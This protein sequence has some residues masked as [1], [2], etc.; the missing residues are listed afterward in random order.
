MTG[1]AT[2]HQYTALVPPVS[3]QCAAGT[4]SWKPSTESRTSRRTS[5][6]RWCTTTMAPS[7]RSTWGRCVG[8]STRWPPPMT[9]CTTPHRK[10]LVPH[11]SARRIRVI[12]EFAQD[13]ARRLWSEGLVDDQIEWMSAVANRLPMMVV[14]RLLGLPE[15]DVDRL[16]RLGYAATTLV[17][18]SLVRPNSKP[19]AWLRWSYPGTSWS[20]SRKPVKAPSRNSSATS[21]TGSRHA[22][23][24]QHNHWRLETEF[25]IL[26]K[27][28]ARKVK[29]PTLLV[30]GEKSPKWL[31][32]IVE[33]LAKNMPNSA[34]IQISGSGHFSHIENPAELNPQI[35]A[36]LE[37]NDGQ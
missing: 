33:G 32:A 13:T 7:P 2:E 18:G 31:Q 27:E 28:D 8:R 25:P 6:R 14:A 1:C 23:G 34:M 11:L 12:E 26:T 15:E 35:L 19:L 10:I 37:K 30:K 36:F 20:T 17:D 22:I 9:R 3:T 16:I 5:P 4:P 24:Q 21:K 29:L